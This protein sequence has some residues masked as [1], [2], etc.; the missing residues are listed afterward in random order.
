MIAPLALSTATTVDSGIIVDVPRRTIARSN[1]GPCL[2]PAQRGVIPNQKDPAAV[3]EWVAAAGHPTAVD[4][5]CGAGGL[6]LGLQDA[7]FSVLVGADSDPASVKS[8]SANLASLGYCGDL[9]DQRAFLKQMRAWGIDRVDLVAGGVP[10]QPFSRAGRSKIRSLVDEGRRPSVDPRASLWRSFIEIVRGLRPRAVL[11]ENVPD[12]TV[13]NNGAIL[14][15]ICQALVRLGYQTDAVLLNAFDY[16]VPQH[17]ARLVVVATRPGLS[18]QWPEQSRRT[19][20][21]DAIGDLPPVPP[22]HL[23]DRI[24][25]DGSSTWLQSRLRRGMS[26]DQSQLVFDH[27]T[28]DVRPDDAEAF[29]LMA[30]GGTYADLPQRLQR[31]RSDIFDDKYKRLA[32]DGLSRS[33][34]AHVAKDGYWYIHP[35]Q[36]RTLSV[37][38]TARIQ[39]FPDWFRFAGHRSS[40]F[41]Q[42]GNA[43]PPLLA[44]AVGAQLAL[45]LSAPTRRG[46]RRGPARSFR[47]ALLAW[48][49]DNRREIPWRE[50]GEPWT[51]LVAERCL[52][53]APSQRISTVYRDVLAAAPSPAAFCRIDSDSTL[54]LKAIG[55]G[56][57]AEEIAAVAEAVLKLHDGRLPTSEQGLL[58]L[59]RVGAYLASTVMVYGANTSTVILDTGTAR[60]AGRIRGSRLQSGNWQARLDL[61]Q[62]AGESGADRAFNSALSDLAYTVCRPAEPLC[63]QCPVMRHCATGRQRA[64]QDDTMRRRHVG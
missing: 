22:A 19:T 12:L 5:F 21:R 39:T 24:E 42:I 52:G 29:S 60:L 18:F 57:A 46:P 7:G 41:R 53:R 56:S 59:P 25:Y 14:A 8:H 34:T 43:V 6:S 45:T 55:V 10:C 50:S 13:W 62:L 26:D 48:H 28:R 40:Q 3:K 63:G 23:E 27:V 1:R 16:G 36:D 37:R 15:S 61:Q 30:E 11:L 49:Q 9:S 51:V 35:S 4:L 64:L 33:I 2:V 47:K 38:E 58:S 20:V 32:W 31:Y 54:R 44:E 17:R